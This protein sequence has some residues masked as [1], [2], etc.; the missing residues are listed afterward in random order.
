MIRPLCVKCNKNLAKTTGTA[1]K[2][3]E[4][5]KAKALNGSIGGF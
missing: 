3:L 5:E 4:I 2:W 1:K